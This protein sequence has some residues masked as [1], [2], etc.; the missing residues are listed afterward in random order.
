MYCNKCGKQIDSGVMCTD[1]LISELATSMAKEAPVKNEPEKATEQP[2]YQAPTYQ[3]PVYQAVMD[4]DLSQ[5]TI[6]EEPP[7]TTTMPEPN[8]RMFGF[9]KALASTIVGFIGYIC[10]FVWLM[11]SV[12]EG[13]GEA[14][15]IL[16]IMLA[17][18]VAI[19]IIFG[20]KSIKTFIARKATCAKPIPT[21]ILGIVG[22]VF[23]AIAALFD[24]LLLLVGS[25]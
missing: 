5:Q 17:P 10:G 25:V 11:M 18:M 2:T 7:V 6:T 9:G 13:M 23:G 16:A 15:L 24:L 8:N 12:A 3:A 4:E 1:C 21:L 19:S 22:A 20:I 14:S